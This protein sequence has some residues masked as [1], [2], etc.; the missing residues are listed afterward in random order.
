MVA[1]LL[2]ALSHPQRL[3]ILCSLSG[4]EM[5]V[6]ELEKVCGSSQSVVSQ[7]LTRMR[8]EGFVAS[9]RDGNFVYYHIVDLRILSLIEELEKIFCNDG[10]C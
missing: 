4:G 2:K 6:S 5:T 7:H 10:E 3:L 1:A 8:L 9:R